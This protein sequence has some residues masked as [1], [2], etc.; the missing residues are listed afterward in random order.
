M[1][2]PEEFN[3]AKI[4]EDAQEVTVTAESIRNWFDGT[5][6]MA[7]ELE[8]ALD[9]AQGDVFTGEKDV[10]YIVIKVTK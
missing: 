6:D 3:Y 7:E 9:Q 10:A 4:K 8:G 5:G 1:S 2:E